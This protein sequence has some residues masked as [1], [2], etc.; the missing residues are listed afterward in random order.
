MLTSQ[1]L[2]VGRIYH[3]RYNGE[4]RIVTIESHGYS[5]KSHK[6]Y[7][8]VSRLE[9]GKTVYRNYFLENIEVL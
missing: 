7:V 4:V 8:T 9:D 2:V 6:D 3:I 1:K 5:K